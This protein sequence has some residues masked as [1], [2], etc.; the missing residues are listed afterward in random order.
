MNPAAKNADSL[1][2]PERRSFLTRA[3][4]VLMGGIVF[5]FPFAAGLGVLF[6]PLRRR[7]SK[8]AGN[9]D[10]AVQFIRICP[11]DALPAD[12]PPQLFPVITEVV[13]AWSH[14]PGQ[15]IGSVFLTRTDADG[16]PNITCFTSTCPH[17][18]CAVDWHKSDDHFECP[19]HVSAFDKDGEKL[20]G[21]ALRGLDR[22]DVK[23]EES[24]GQ[25]NVL[26]AYERFRTGIAERIPIG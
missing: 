16:K 19:C 22:L 4:T 2:L 12:G 26:V 24:D 1:R 8:G 25:T 6:D 17:L 15:R 9:A 14:T 10:E 5:I 21:P 11:L 7:K 20:F 18:G 3:V 13:D 23:L